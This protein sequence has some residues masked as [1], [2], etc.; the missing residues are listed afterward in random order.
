LLGQTGIN[1]TISGSFNTTA[2]SVGAG[3]GIAVSGVTESA[4]GTQIA[5]KF[6]IAA[7]AS[8]GNHDVKVSDSGG[9]SNA[10]KFTVN[11]RTAI[12]T[13]S[14]NGSKTPGDNLIYGTG[15]QTCTEILG[16]A[17]CSRKGFWVWNVEVQV[18]V[19][20]DAASWT[21]GQVGVGRAKG[22]TVNPSGPPLSFDEPLSFPDD[23]PAPAFLQQIPGQKTIFWIDAPGH[24]ITHTSIPID[25]M[26]EVENFTS[27]VCSTI[28]TNS[29]FSVNWFLK[30]VVD[31]SGRLDF[32][33]SAAGMGTA[34]LNF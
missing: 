33:S 25:S 26:T 6:D 8:V 16:E 10:A 17:D 7:T 19:N 5:A 24:R 27:T 21:V 1:V 18:T 9:T 4:D 14:F 23:A 31:A 12:L 34:S 13:V 22:F 32:S 15:T 29:C 20:D 11:P 28:V 2:P 30:L 3:S